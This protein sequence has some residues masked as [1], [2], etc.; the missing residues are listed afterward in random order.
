MHT[1]T[2][3]TRRQFIATATAAAAATAAHA[4]AP[5]AAPAPAPAGPFTL[6]PLPYAQDALEPHIDALTMG[7]HHGKHHKAYVD[8]LNKALAP[9]A[10]LQKKTV[11][12]LIAD[13]AFLPEDIRKPVQ[14]NGGGH[15]NHSL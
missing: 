7:I 12:Q 9:H 14:N 2:S 8:N 4:Q 1:S 3:T 6:D 10:D 15:W 11:A 5:A 13:I